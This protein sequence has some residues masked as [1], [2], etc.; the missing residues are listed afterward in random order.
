MFIQLQVLTRPAVSVSAVAILPVGPIGAA[1]W[2][3]PLL[4]K[5]V[6]PVPLLSSANVPLFVHV[7]VFVDAA[8]H[9]P[10]GVAVK[11]G[12]RVR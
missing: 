11:L 3:A 9:R 2:P 6:K 8:E 5:Q 7:V 1:V 4:L 12:K 10:L